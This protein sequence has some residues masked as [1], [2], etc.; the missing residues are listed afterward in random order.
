MNFLKGG[1]PGST[2]SLQEFVQSW[3]DFQPVYS[4]EIASRVQKEK[5][6]IVL[7]MDKWMES[8]PATAAKKT[9]I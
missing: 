7:W 2:K 1:K 9:L 4:G 8:C 6:I 5:K 3:S